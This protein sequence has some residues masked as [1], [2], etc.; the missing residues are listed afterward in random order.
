VPRGVTARHYLETSRLEY[1]LPEVQ[2]IADW[3][4]G[5]GKVAEA[6]ASGA[7]VVAL[8]AA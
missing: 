3:I 7:N 1:L 4:A 5:Q 2:R 6:M 8:R